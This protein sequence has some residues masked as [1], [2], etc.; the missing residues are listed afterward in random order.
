MRAGLGA[1][2]VISSMLVAWLPAMP[3]SADDGKCKVDGD[4]GNVIGRCR[5]KKDDLHE[6]Q[7]KGDGARWRM[8]PYLWNPAAPGTDYQECIT[9][10]GEEGIIYVV[11]RNDVEVG[12][13][14][15][16]PEDRAEQDNPIRLVIREFHRLSW[17]GST[18]S[19]QPPG[20]R[21]LVNLRTIFFT[22]NTEP[23]VQTVRLVGK[24]V[25][26]EATPTEYTWHFGD[27]TSRATTSP[28]RPYP[29][30]DVVH[31]FARKGAVSA[32]V[33][34]TYRGRYRLDGGPWMD[35][36]EPHTVAGQSVR[37]QVLEARP[38]LVRD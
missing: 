33:D 32:R 13:V 34:T 14:C 2:L 5:W 20:G 6:E 23:T 37:L 35:I 10:D 31:T 28:G 18:L 29:D 3:A 11:Y 9:D 19:V 17:P 30:E 22:T 36:P 26:I 1:V 4:L 7:R 16:S 12:R 27:G 25:E 24:Q 38:H 15:F 21:T 8:E